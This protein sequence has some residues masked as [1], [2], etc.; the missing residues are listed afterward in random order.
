MKTYVP[1]GDRIE[2]AKCAVEFAHLYGLRPQQL[3][4]GMLEAVAMEPEDRGRMTEDRGRMT[5]DG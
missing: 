4:H 3:Y 1:L 2:L 5:E